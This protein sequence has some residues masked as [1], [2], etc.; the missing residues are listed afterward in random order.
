MCCYFVPL[1]GPGR[2]VD[3]LFS[4]IS[5]KLWKTEEK[6]I[7]EKKPMKNIK[8]TRQ[9]KTK[10]HKKPKERERE[11]KKKGDVPIWYIDFDPL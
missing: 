5:W 2:L 9:V 4:S 10:I 3:F 11:E 1:L 8:E 7:L 6:K